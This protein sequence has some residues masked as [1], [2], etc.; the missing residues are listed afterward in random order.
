MI[1]LSIGIRRLVLRVMSLRTWAILVKGRIL[2]PIK[3]VRTSLLVA[4]SALRLEN[5]LYETHSSL[6]AAFTSSIDPFPL[7]EQIV[8]C[9]ESDYA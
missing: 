5:W 3:R 7:P 8:V 4:L 2:F 6:L 9:S 1:T